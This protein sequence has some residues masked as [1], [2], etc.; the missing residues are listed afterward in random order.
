MRIDQKHRPWLI[1]V[2]TAAGLATGLYVAAPRAPTGSFG[3][4]GS[5]LALGVV[6]A[7]LIAV[8]SL[9]GVR[10]RF[11]RLPL[12]PV[13]GWLR[14]H[15]WLALLSLLLALYH[16]GF[17]LGGILSTAVTLLLILCVVSG[18]LGA[19][20]QHILPGEISARAAAES[21][22]DPVRVIALA[23]RQAYQT[24]WTVC[25]GF[26]EAAADAAAA[27]ERDAIGE[28]LGEPPRPPEPALRPKSGAL[29]GGQ[30]L[31]RFYSGV[32]LPFFWK[33][34]ALRSPLANAADAA[35]AFD[36]CAAGVAE[37]LH[38]TVEELSELCERVR[39]ARRQIRM[40]SWLH[41]WLLA[42]VPLA[43]ALLV[44]LLVHAVTALRY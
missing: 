20:L 36:A 44:L 42:H 21:A 5:G 19:F 24:I 7:A 29:A 41:G 10:R 32:M 33:S 9:L 28:L 39:Q 17:R 3:S 13:A 40:Q 12:G 11:P 38:P 34:R 16:G 22:G 6:G 23:R 1:G 14:G 37:A 26:P 30:E 18:V 15:L 25:G 8:V 35:L 27:A 4:T 2:L 43:M 31:A